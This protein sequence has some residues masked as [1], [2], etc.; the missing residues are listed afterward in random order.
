MQ[1]YCY[2][3]LNCML[4]QLLVILLVIVS[5][6][7]TSG[8]LL[9]DDIWKLIA[10]SSAFCT[11]RKSYCTGYEKKKKKTE[12]EREEHE[13]EQENE[14]EK[15]EEKEE[16]EDEEKE[17]EQ[18]KEEKKQQQFINVLQPKL[19]WYNKKTKVNHMQIA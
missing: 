3:L 19:D 8:S 5:P 1:L 16:K 14:E 7:D 6:Y 18:E 9:S 2:K 17:Q 13:V 15:E 4:K 10:L 11:S 12:K